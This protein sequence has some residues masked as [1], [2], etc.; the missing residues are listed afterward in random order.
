MLAPW[1]ILFEPSSPLLDSQLE[2]NNWKIN[3]I[4]Y[5]GNSA[6]RLGF[7]EYRIKDNLVRAT[8]EGERVYQIFERRK[9]LVT[10]RLW[11]VLFTEHSKSH[12]SQFDTRLKLI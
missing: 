8:V 10:D 1:I 11:F 4:I 7:A 12:P 3:W 6:W 5:I 2:R 9:N